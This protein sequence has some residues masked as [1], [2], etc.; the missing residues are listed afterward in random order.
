MQKLNKGYVFSIYLF[1]IVYYFLPRIQFSTHSQLWNFVFE[2][3]NICVLAISIL[4]LLVT[5][6][7]AYLNKWQKLNLTHMVIN[8]YVL[9]FLATFFYLMIV[10]FIWWLIISA[11]L[12]PILRL[13][14]NKQN[15]VSEGTLKKFNVNE[16]P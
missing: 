10:A 11:V 4:M 7:K 14:Q 6:Q 5:F 1:I 13:I 8:S 12:F 2:F 15:P 9:Y 16:L 3:R